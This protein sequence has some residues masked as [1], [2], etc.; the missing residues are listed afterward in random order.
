MKFFNAPS[1][2]GTSVDY[3]KNAL[4]IFRLIA[5]GQ[6][7]LGH[8]ITHFKMNS[9]PIS[10]IYFLRGVPILFALCGFLAAK[11]LEKY[12]TK[13]WLINRATRI[14]PAFWVCIIINFIIISF[15]YPQKPSGP[16]A[17]IYFATQFL[18]LN[19]YTGDWLRDYGVGVPNGVLWTISAQIQFFLLAPLFK[20]LFKKIS[21]KR[22]F[23]FIG[24]LSLL[25]LLCNRIFPFLP[26]TVAKLITVT[27]LPYLYFLAGGMFLWYHRE[28]L[29]PFLKNNK[30][31]FS[32]LYC[33]WKILGFFGLT[34]LFDGIHYN[35][36]STLL[37]LC[38]VFGFSFSYSWRMPRDYTYGF[39]LYHMVVINILIEF[40]FNSL[41]SPWQCALLLFM[42]FAFSSLLAI[43][44]HHLIE[45]NL[46]TII[47]NLFKEKNHG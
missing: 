30:W 38:V 8:V 44:S 7:F 9:A 28:K 33:L 11:S 22:G 14:L 23:L 45:I 46:T 10:A 19:F 25:P 35:V 36:I 17:I 16:E 4:D 26:S 27:A 21:L 13:K 40:S 12:S 1:S 6:V 3:N 18:G 41:L 32:F 42:I 47:K 31:Q 29:F 15:I 24:I 2:F 43:L 5:T 37:L 39:Y 34:T 20:K